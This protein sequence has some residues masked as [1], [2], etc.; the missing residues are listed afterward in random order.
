MNFERNI[1][2]KVVSITKLNI[3]KKKHFPTIQIFVKQMYYTIIIND[4]EILEFLI[5]LFSILAPR[6]ILT[7]G[8]E[9]SPLEG[10]HTF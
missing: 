1:L 4:Y 9:A 2:R 7:T 10:N 8:S 3:E 6:V 5:S